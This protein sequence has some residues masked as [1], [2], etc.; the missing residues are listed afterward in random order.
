MKM[1]LLAASVMC[2]MPLLATDLA[3]ADRDD[4]D[5]DDRHN[6]YGR[7]ARNVIFFVGDG[8]GVST[9]TATRIF[10]VGVDGQLV[11]DQIPYTALSRTS[12]TDHITPDSAGTM[13]SMMTGVNT[14]SGLIGMSPDTERNDFNGDG[15][16][17]KLWTVL[18]Q[19]KQ[20]GMK[21][22]VI[23]TPRVTHATPAA[24]Y[25]HVNERNKENDIA[26]QALPT[27]S[28]YNTRLGKG[29]DLL[30]GGGRR[31]FCPSPLLDEEG[32]SC[33]RPDG[34]DL[35]DEFQDAGYTYVWN[36][37]DFDDLEKD[38]LPVLGLFERSHMEYEFDRPND[39]GT[40][41][42]LEAMTRKAIK[43]LSNNK[44]Y[45]LMVEGGRIDHAHHASNAFR[46]LTDTVEFD[47]AVGAALEMVDLRDTL[48]VV[49]ADHSH[50]FTIAG[51]P[52]REPADIPYSFNNA[53][54]EY[55]DN[56]PAT[57]HGIMDVVYDI[58]ADTGD[59][60]VKNA[61]DGVPY[62]ILGY[63]NGELPRGI[64]DPTTSEGDPDYKQESA[65]PLSS[66]THS[67]EEVAIYA[68]GPQSWRFNGTV[69]NSFIADVMRKALRFNNPN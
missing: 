63:T 21:V 38:D 45:F 32:D 25:A 17:D 46:S 18:E 1:K 31:Y 55:L 6:A 57:N 10:S 15:D 33:S 54:A 19:A 52:M 47:Q 67:A 23:S 50:V 27:D 7:K 26:L 66:E 44:G 20:H 48:V 58:N 16:G 14:N 30:M 28:T 12:T 69:K 13:T 9:V 40:E 59:I 8:M 3:F 35:R 51:Y 42:S 39:V 53:P 29:L 41:P 4:H 60:Y 61:S 43:L 65:V 49:T 37:S 24:S 2:V 68:A 22:G 34:R 56:G 62:T 64:V 36:E 11:M 5:D